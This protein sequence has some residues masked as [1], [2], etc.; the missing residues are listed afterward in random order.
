[1]DYN[2]KGPYTYNEE[3]VGGWDSTAIGIY[4]CGYLTTQGKL[5]PLYIGVGT[6]DEGIRGRLLDHL[7]E[8]YWPDATHFVYRLCSTAQEAL[9]WERREIAAHRPK[10]NKIGK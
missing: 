3:I 8:D 2:H 5:Y 10:Y 9:D 1:M 7:N 4:Y 6:S